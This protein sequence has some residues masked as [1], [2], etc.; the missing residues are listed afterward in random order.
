MY[1]DMTQLINQYRDMYVDMT[2]QRAC[3]SSTSMNFP[4]FR[5]HPRGEGT[6]W[7]LGEFQA[8]RNCALLTR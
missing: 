8:V 3:A 4:N 6:K 2:L 1:V 7:Y 5:V